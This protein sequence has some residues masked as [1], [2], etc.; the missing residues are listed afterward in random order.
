MNFFL[1]III[2]SFGP[3]YDILNKYVV[4]NKKVNKLKEK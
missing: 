4:T 1:F 3:I 2:N